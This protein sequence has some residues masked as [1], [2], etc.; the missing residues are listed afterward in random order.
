M[1]DQKQKIKGSCILNLHTRSPSSTGCLQDEAL[2]MAWDI[3]FTSPI[4]SPFI[5]T[6][7]DIIFFALDQTCNLFVFFQ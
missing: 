2:N 7:Q 5:R 6:N 3:F 4:V 1:F